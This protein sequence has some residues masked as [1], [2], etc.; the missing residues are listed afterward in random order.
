MVQY[1]KQ[2]WKLNYEV[3]T[4][5]ET[6]PSIYLYIKNDMPLQAKSQ[7]CCWEVMEW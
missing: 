2:K 7:C 6:K 3:C 5:T 1:V 4:K